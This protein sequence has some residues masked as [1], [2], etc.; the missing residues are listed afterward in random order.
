MRKVKY[1]DEKYCISLIKSA[2]SPNGKNGAVNKCAV[3][4]HILKRVENIKDQYG[5]AH[6]DL[7]SEICFNFLRK[8]VIRKINSQKGSPATFILH[9]VF[10]ELRNIERSCAR[11]TFDKTHKNC[12][13]M[14]KVAFHFEDL[15]NNGNWI[16]ELTD[17]D[18]PE[19]LMI[20][21]QTL[22]QLGYL[23]GDPQLSVLLGQISMDEYSRIT[24]LSRR[25]FYSRLSHNRP[26]VE[27]L[28]GSTIP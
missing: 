15:D 28:L 3:K 8:S 10:N 22:D 20:A 26:M 18:N 16:P 21:Q 4:E 24:G 2:L 5:V 7:F 17:Y 1:Y 13:A 6:E 11:G 27:A 25:S 14:D 12:D 19:T 9:Y 23:L